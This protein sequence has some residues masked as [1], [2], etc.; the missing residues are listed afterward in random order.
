MEE[1]GEGLVAVVGREVRPM[2]KEDAYCMSGGNDVE[3]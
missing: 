2:E 3:S 1:G